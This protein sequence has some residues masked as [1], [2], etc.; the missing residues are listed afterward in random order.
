MLGSATPE[1]YEFLDMR[2][3]RP[4]V[5]RGKIFP[6][7]ENAYQSTRFSSDDTAEKFRYM[8]PDTAAYKGASFRTTVT[9]WKQDRDK[10]LYEVLHAKFSDPAMAKLL[11]DTGDVPICLSNRR[12]ENDLGSCSCPRCRN[13]GKNIAGPVLERIREELASQMD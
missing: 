12:H 2:Y 1:R 7:A 8:P 4:F 9:G 10:Y 13:R 11:A 6:S 5:F 3:E